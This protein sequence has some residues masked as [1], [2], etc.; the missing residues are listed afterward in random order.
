MRR[1]TVRQR[2]AVRQWKGCPVGQPFFV[3]K[4]DTVDAD[5]V[6]ADTVNADIVNAGTADAGTAGT[7]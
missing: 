4:V 5:T 7:S 6:N 1:L 3:G 2:T